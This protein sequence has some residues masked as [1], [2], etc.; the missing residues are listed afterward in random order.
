MVIF[1]V[2]A[3]IGA[4]DKQDTLSHSSKSVPKASEG[5]LKADS[6]LADYEIELA[7][8]LRRLQEKYPRLENWEGIIDKE[9][10]KGEALA[11]E[12][13]AVK[14]ARLNAYKLYAAEKRTAV[15]RFYLW[16][17]FYNKPIIDSYVESKPDE[18]KDRIF[19]YICRV[20]PASVAENAHV[21]DNDQYP[22]TDNE[23]S[24]EYAMA[25]P[26]LKKIP[27]YLQ[28]I[29]T[30]YSFYNP[31]PKGKWWAKWRAFAHLL[32]HCYSLPIAKAYEND[33]KN[34][35]NNVDCDMNGKSLLD[36]GTGSG[37]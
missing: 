32:R 37:V 16:E 36:V 31:R 2:L 24:A 5:I 6:A 27:I 12:C 15:Y 33:I 21:I 4:I 3:K 35:L 34:A 14:Q 26:T 1:L 29:K 20:D 23:Y 17:K 28:N 18:Y 30:D 19:A 25:N 7:A 11:A 8:L 9:E 10:A 22:L 13:R